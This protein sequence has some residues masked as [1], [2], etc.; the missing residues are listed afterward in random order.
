MKIII[1]GRSTGRGAFTSAGFP[2]VNMSKT[3]NHWE[4]V[5]EGEVGDEFMLTD[6]TNSGKH[7]C[8]RCRITGEGYYGYDVVERSQ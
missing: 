3:G 8:R 7:E 5:L 6:I 1:Q 2:K 4:E